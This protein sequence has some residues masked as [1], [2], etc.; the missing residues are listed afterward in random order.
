MDAKNETLLVHTACMLTI[1]LSF[2]LALT[3]LKPYPVPAS[4]LTGGALWLWGKLAFKPASP[5]LAN[6]LQQ[7]GP[8]QVATLS[9]RPP[10]PAIAGAP[11]VPALPMTTV[12]E[13]IRE[14]MRTGKVVVGSN[15]IDD[16]GLRADSTPDRPTPVDPP[17][18]KP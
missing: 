5:V 1:A 6:I 3:L 15:V 9:Q 18:V 10:A 16:V 2:T 14:S 8:A 11:S 7:L 12:S 17:K 13:V 4:I